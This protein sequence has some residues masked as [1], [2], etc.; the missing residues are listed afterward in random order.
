MR[1]FFVQKFYYTNTSKEVYNKLGN[2]AG[3][4]K[5]F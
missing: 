1:S 5:M 4:F 2:V 3:I